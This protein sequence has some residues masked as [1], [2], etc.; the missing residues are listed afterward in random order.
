MDIYKWYLALT[1]SS[2]RSRQG[3][4]KDSN[5]TLDGTTIR[6][7][8]ISTCTDPHHLHRIQLIF[9]SMD[10]LGQF[11]VILQRNNNIYLFARSK[12]DWRTAIIEVM[13][14][15]TT[16]TQSYLLSTVA[17]IKWLNDCDWTRYKLAILLR[18]Q[19]LP[20][21]KI[22]NETSNGWMERHVRLCYQNS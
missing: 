8:I 3:L 17:K 7:Y 11:I 14:H 12:S 18:I 19:F 6:Q 13:N 2:L 16:L 9:L 15:F 1:N 5:S 22:Y 4:F 20:L 21:I 10:T